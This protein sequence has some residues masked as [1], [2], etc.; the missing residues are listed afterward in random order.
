MSGNSTTH[1]I[2]NSIKRSARNARGVQRFLRTMVGAT[3]VGLAGVASLGVLTN[4]QSV[5]GKGLDG[6]DEGPTDEAVLNFALTLEYLEAEFYLRATSGAGLPESGVDGSGS[7][8]E[9][10]GGHKV[11]FETTLARQFAEEIAADERGHVEYFRRELGTAKVARPAIDLR[12]AFTVAAR[13]AGVIDATQTFDP[14][15]DENSFLLGAFLFEDVGVTAFKGAAPLI[16]NKNYLEAAA[17][18]L[19]TEAYHAGLV[20]SLLLDK[21]LSEAASKISQARDSLDGPGRRDQGVLD[22]AGK[23]NVVPTDDDGIVYTRTPGQVLNIVYLNPGSVRS[24]GFFPNG[25]NA[26]VDTSGPHS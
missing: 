13:A 25:I 15:A 20:R 12:D 23:A 14:F 10:T 21:G 11:P 9:V 26:A 1:F 6:A 19:A 7:L 18:I 3:G 2:T 5:G 4:L 16:N 22:E 24:G 8:G 17:G